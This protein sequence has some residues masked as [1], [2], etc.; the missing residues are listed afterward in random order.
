MRVLCRVVYYTI[1]TLDLK[2]RYLFCNIYYIQEF[3]YEL[4]Q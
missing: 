4:V 2:C 1:V 3:R